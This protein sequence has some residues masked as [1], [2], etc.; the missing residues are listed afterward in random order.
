MSPTT[1]SRNFIASIR[2]A[3]RSLEL[4]FCKLNRIRYDAPWRT[5]GARRC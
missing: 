4:A 3:L 2:E 5:D 1:R